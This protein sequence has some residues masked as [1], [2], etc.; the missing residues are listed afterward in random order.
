MHYLKQSNFYILKKN[1]STAQHRREEALCWFDKYFSYQYKKKLFL[2]YLV[3]K[4]FFFLFTYFIIQSNG[5]D[6]HS[7]I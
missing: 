6:P 2:Q 5:R 1:G 7:R 4:D 3:K